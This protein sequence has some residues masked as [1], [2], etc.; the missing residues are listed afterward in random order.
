MSTETVDDPAVLLIAKA[1]HD[2]ACSDR[3][4]AF[5]G[6]FADRARALAAKLRAGGYLSP[7]GVVLEREIGHPFGHGGPIVPCLEGSCPTKPTV[8]RVRVGNWRAIES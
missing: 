1:L 3:N 7:P 5:H 4:C 8:E 6:V 2:A